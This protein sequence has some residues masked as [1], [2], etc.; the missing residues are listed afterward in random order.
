MIL[1]TPIFQDKIQVKDIMEEKGGR[2]KV[3][4]ERKKMKGQKSRRKDR[5]WEVGK[6]R[7]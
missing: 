1:P 2:S 5:R 4:G 7:R 3:E 6:V